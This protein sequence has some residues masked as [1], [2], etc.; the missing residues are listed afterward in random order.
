MRVPGFFCYVFKCCLVFL[1]GTTL[2]TDKKNMVWR[3]LKEGCFADRFL[4]NS[5]KRSGH[6]FILAKTLHMRIIAHSCC[7]FFCPRFVSHG[8][9]DDSWSSDFFFWWSLLLWSHIYFPNCSEWG[10]AISSRFIPRPGWDVES[11]WVH[12][13][14]LTKQKTY[15]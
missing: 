9:L 10:S 5:P 2:E 13:T 8:I 6:R 3:T 4:G 7:A 14:G 1:L 11:C 15:S 12:S